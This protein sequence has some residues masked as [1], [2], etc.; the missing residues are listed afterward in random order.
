MTDFPLATWRGH[1]GRLLQI[2]P[3]QPHDEPA[4][5]AL[6]AGLD[7]LSRRRRFHGAVNGLAPASLHALARAGGPGRTVLV[8]TA[9]RDGQDTLV[10]E[11]RCV[12]DDSGSAAEFAL[13]V[14]PGWRR[15]GIARRCLQAL[16]EAAGEDGLHWLYGHVLTDNLPM[17]ALLHGCGF[18]LSPHRGDT[19]LV[20]AERPCP[21]MSPAVVPAA[22][23]PRTRPAPIRHC[24]HCLTH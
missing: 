1:D 16:H 11:A 4:L 5:A 22:P 23:S 21:V 13:A 15:E 17:L 8:A 12:V 7:P 20:V 3:I 18:A 6:F 24:L 14:A 9:A 10:A 19:R 2:R